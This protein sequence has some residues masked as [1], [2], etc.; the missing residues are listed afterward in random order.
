MVGYGQVPHDGLSFTVI[1]TIIVGLG[2]PGALVILGGVYV[3]IKKKPWQNVGKMIA[4]AR[5]RDGYEPIH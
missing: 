1:I 3:F 2:I 5:G 4:K